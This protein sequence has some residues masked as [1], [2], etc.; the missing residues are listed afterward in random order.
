MQVGQIDRYVVAAAATLN[1]C[2]K[3][4][5]RAQRCAAYAGKRCARPS[6]T[7]RPPFRRGQ[8]E[9]RR[10]HLAG[11]RRRLLLA[12]PARPWRSAPPADRRP[13]R[14]ASVRS[15]RIAAHHAGMPEVEPHALT[16]RQVATT[17]PPAPALQRRPQRRRGRTA[18][19]RPASARASPADAAAARAARCRRSTGA[20]R[21]GDSGCAHRCAPPAAWCRR[22]V[23]SKRPLD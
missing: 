17:P 3:L 18:R 20:P 12:T 16:A 15:S 4:I 9:Q 10:A 8:R 11:K 19:R 2:G 21:P 22:A 23:P 13:A 7:S 6:S 14:P 5:E 1:D